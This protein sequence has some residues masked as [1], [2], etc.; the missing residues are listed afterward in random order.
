MRREALTLLVLAELA[1][2]TA[3]DS[4]GSLG[5]VF[6]AGFIEIRIPQEIGCIAELQYTS[7]LHVAKIRHDYTH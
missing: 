4:L 7:K 3:L 1:T 2:L 6:L 5:R